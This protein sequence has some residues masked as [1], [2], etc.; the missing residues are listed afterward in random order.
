MLRFDVIQEHGDVAHVVLVEVYRDA[1]AAAAHKQTAHYA[2]WRDTVAPMM[3]EPRRSAT[4][5]AV[6]PH[7]SER[8]ATR[9]TP[10]AVPESDLDG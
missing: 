1:D 8:W 10:K 6:F 3:A 4:F 2:T 7:D 5:A 9:T